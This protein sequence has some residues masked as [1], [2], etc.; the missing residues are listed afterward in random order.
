MRLLLV[1]ARGYESVG[2]GAENGGLRDIVRKRFMIDVQVASYGKCGG[3][4]QEKSSRSIVVRHG[5][6]ET[7]VGPHL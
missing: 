5:H 3:G 1:P 4:F 2:K 6:E 7:S